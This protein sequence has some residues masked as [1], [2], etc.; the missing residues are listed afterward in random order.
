MHTNILKLVY[1][2]TYCGYKLT[3]VYFCAHLLVLLLYISYEKLCFSFIGKPTIFIFPCSWRKVPLDI[4]L[5]ALYQ[6]WEPVFSTH[7][8]STNIPTPLEFRGYLQVCNLLP[9]FNFMFSLFAPCGCLVTKCNNCRRVQTK[10]EMSA[11]K[12]MCTTVLTRTCR[13]CVICVEMLWLW[14]LDFS[15]WRLQS[16][17]V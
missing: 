2:R 4:T 12:S 7:V 15:Q 16:Y 5:F 3:S 14:Y 11:A 1:I 8:C 13:S 17:G 9:T 10:A 6:V